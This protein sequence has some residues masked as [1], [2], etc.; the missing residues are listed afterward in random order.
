MNCEA[1]W[2]SCNKPQLACR[3][4][5]EQVLAPA[6]SQHYS[7]AKMEQAEQI[8]I[9]ISIKVQQP[10]TCMVTTANNL[11]ILKK[12]PDI[13]LTIRVATKPAKKTLTNQDIALPP[14][15]RV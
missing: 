13:L 3:L 9:R 15:D 2:L 1:H 7:Q 4:K 14:Q 6:A 10:A 5:G 11:L 8:N 12:N